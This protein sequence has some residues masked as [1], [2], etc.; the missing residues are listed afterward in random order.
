M[1]DF[2]NTQLE[3]R[4]IREF[5]DEPFPQETYLTLLEVAR[6]TATSSG[7]QASSIIRITDV[8][9]KQ[10]IAEI[11]HQEYIARLPL[12]MIFIVDQYR[13]NQIAVEQ[14]IISDG[15]AGMDG[16]FQS[17]T[18]ACLMA[19]NIVNAAESLQLGTLYIGSIHN[20]PTA[21]C[22]LL[23][24]PPLTFP[25]VALG[26]G[27]ANQEPVLKPRM[28]M[29]LRSFDNTYVRVENYLSQLKE[30]DQ[31]M[32]TYYDL[33]DTNRRLDS[34]SQQVAK[35]IVSHNPVRQALMNVVVDQG[36]DLRLK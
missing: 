24:L 19:Q 34:F 33:R 7:L 15:A 14:G 4:T 27:I 10:K 32:Q 6:R 31:I 5:K 29:S 28:S 13:N 18:D 3:H 20:D 16:F 1:N 30:Y 2:I 35:R 36:F 17:F 11:C 23:D 21:L 12:L 9:L 25:V 22:R 8:Q 26:L